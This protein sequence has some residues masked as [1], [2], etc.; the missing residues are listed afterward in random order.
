MGVDNRVKIR[1]FRTLTI[2][3]E[4]GET[5]V[6]PVYAHTYT[7]KYA[8]EHGLQPRRPGRGVLPKKF[9]FYTVGTIV[10]K[11]EDL[12]KV[13]K[14]PLNWPGWISLATSSEVQ[15]DPTDKDNGWSKLEFSGRYSGRRYKRVNN[16]YT[17]GEALAAELTTAQL[18]DAMVHDDVFTADDVEWCLFGNKQALKRKAMSKLE[19]VNAKAIVASLL[20]DDR[21]GFPVRWRDRRGR[22]RKYKKDDAPPAEDHDGERPMAVLQRAADR[23]SKTEIGSLFR[24]L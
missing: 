16:S 7:Q 10:L 17:A 23:F 13:S 19:N 4:T 11:G 15:I 12:K 1:K 8:W 9:S 3:S 2:R 5:V 21:P 20:L 22:D 18:A 24:H 14:H 6:L